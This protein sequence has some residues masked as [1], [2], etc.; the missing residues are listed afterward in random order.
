MKSP[1]DAGKLRW[2]NSNGY[3]ELIAA[4]KEEPDRLPCTCELECSVP[5]CR[6]L[7]G[8]DACALAWSVYVDDHAL[9]DDAGNLITPPEIQ[10]PWSNVKNPKLIF[11]RCNAG[12]S[13][14]NP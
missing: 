9:W 1:T 10:G 2:P 12:V 3:L 11:E 6:G 13:V 5:D 4:S 14:R 8:C 7:C